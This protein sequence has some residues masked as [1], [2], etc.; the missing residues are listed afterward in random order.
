MHVFV[1]K[2]EIE[3]NHLSEGLL[4]LDQHRIGRP[5]MRAELKWDQ[6][7]EFKDFSAWT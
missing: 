7:K 4:N 3:P 6:N 1:L 5:L 2:T